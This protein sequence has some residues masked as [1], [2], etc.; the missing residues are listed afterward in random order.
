MS[1]PASPTSESSNSI[2]EETLTPGMQFA[3]IC[4]VCLRWLHVW[5]RSAEEIVEQ[6]VRTTA[7]VQVC[8]NASHLFRIL[9]SVFKLVRAA[10]SC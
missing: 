9:R 4:G 1:S 7:V 6:G 8:R 5:L 2:V 10:C 3:C